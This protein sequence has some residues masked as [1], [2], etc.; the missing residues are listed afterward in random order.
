[1]A[2]RVV[3]G[4]FSVLEHTPLTAMGLTLLACCET[5]LASH[6]LVVGHH[7]SM[8]SSRR[9]FLN[10]VGASTFIVSA[11]PTSYRAS[12]YLTSW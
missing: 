9:T 1:V 7:G 10:A 6:I 8:T 2:L 11:G 4:T 5:D 3:A 12:Y